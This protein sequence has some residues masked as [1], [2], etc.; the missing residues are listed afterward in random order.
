MPTLSSSLLPF[1][2]PWFSYTK[3]SLPPLN[4]MLGVRRKFS[5]R[6]GDGIVDEEATWDGKVWRRRY[7]NEQ[8]PLTHYYA[9]RR[10][11]V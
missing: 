2:D 1:I 10:Y 6:G 8:F 7:D 3:D 5:N 9:W 4:E 11:E